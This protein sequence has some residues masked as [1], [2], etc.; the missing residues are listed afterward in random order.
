M[1]SALRQLE[2]HSVSS[3]VSGITPTGSR[4]I[5]ASVILTNIN[6][7]Y[8]KYSRKCTKARFSKKGVQLIKSVAAE[9]TVRLA[10]IFR[11]LNSNNRLRCRFLGGE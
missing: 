1:P 5:K 10:P 2:R 3:F 6:W 7:G 4:L 8:P 11:C 9:T